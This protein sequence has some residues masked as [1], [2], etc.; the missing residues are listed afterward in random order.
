MEKRKE[1]I[2]LKT[3][4]KEVPI[5]IKLRNYIFQN[6]SEIINTPKLNKQKLTLS[7]IKRNLQSGNSSFRTETFETNYQNIS[8]IDFYP[9]SEN[10]ARSS[11]ITQPNTFRLLID[12]NYSDYI[13]RLKKLYPLFKFN[14][15]SKYPEN[16]FKI[17]SFWNSKII[18]NNKHNNIINNHIIEEDYNESFLLDSLGLQDNIIDNED[19]FIIKKDFLERN[20]IDELIMIKDDL[21]FKMG[22]IDKEINKI[23]SDNTNSLFNY[24]ENNIS[25]NYEIDKNLNNLTLIRNSKRDLN[26]KYIDN[27]VKLLLKGSKKKKLCNLIEILKEFMTLYN[28]SKEL[29]N[30]EESDNDNKIKELSNILEKGRNIIKQ[31]RKNDKLRKLNAINDIE[32]YFLNY[33]NKGEENLVLEF[34]KYVQRIFENCLIFDKKNFINE[35][36]E[37]KKTNYNLEKDDNQK[38]N[39]K[40]I[41]DDFIKDNFM[42]LLIYNNLGEDSK[43]G[44]IYNILLSIIELLNLIIKDN[45]DIFSIIESLN[46]IFKN[47]ILNNYEKIQQLNLDEPEKI[48]ILSHCYMIII[49]NYYYILILFTNN[50]GLAPKIF[51]ELTNFINLEMN[52]IIKALISGY[53]HLNLESDNIK[54]FIY[55]CE[56]MN[57]KSK[58]FLEYNKINWFDFISEINDEFIQNYY[59][60]NSTFLLDKLNEEDWN[61]LKNIDSQYQDIFDLINDTDINKIEEN[62]KFKKFIFIEIKDIEKEKEEENI[63]H[64]I[65]LKNNSKDSKFKIIHFFLYIIKLIYESLFLFSYLKYKSRNTIILRIYKLI[66]QILLKAKNII[67]D[68]SDGKI[69]NK[70]AITEKESSLLNSITYLIEIFLQKFFLISPDNKLQDNLNDIKKSTKEMMTLLL[71]IVIDETINSIEEINFEKYPI[72]QSKQYNS[73]ILKFTKMKKIYDNM[74]YGFLT[75]DIIQIYNEEFKKLFEKM[76]NVISNKPHIENEN[77]FKQFRKEM[78]YIK[79]VLEMF[80]LIDV[81]EYIEKI[82]KISKIVNP[83]KV[84]KKKK[85]IDKKDE[86]EEK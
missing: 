71:N 53:L 37:N 85:K 36:F 15:Y 7:N 64:F 76:E 6:F 35:I 11:N 57:E 45:V 66:N 70:K 9:E 17:S 5:N 16:E 22:L 79:K 28:I 84:V 62:E 41:E 39:L 73:Y 24:I 68:S 26:K 38:N 34:S 86:D 60:N 8:D 10:S 31:L 74:L 30:I 75:E 12:Q 13:T 33:E 43:N 32:K 77:E 59:D 65:I 14:H 49:S 48:Y 46:Q 63:N 44:K 67:I 47:L 50:Y 83:N 29:R 61:Q 81:K 40:L 23:V 20:N 19:Q 27:S 4:L 42:F 82:E 52:K 80:D 56:L 18:I 51:I 58:D 55:K 3:N 21:V 72:F 1:Q 78:N 54:E 2:N 25:I 69:N